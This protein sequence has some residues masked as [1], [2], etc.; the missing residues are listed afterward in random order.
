MTGKDVNAKGNDHSIIMHGEQEAIL[1]E[2]GKTPG[3]Y[4]FKN[5]HHPLILAEAQEDLPR[6]SSIEA[7]NTQDANE[8]ARAPVPLPKKIHTHNQDT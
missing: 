2:N 3:I 8:E 7:S 1:I 4:N 6:S 5:K